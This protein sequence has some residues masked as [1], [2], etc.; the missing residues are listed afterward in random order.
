MGGP[1]LT[2]DDGWL[3]A[4]IAASPGQP[5]H[6]LEGD[7]VAEHVPGCNMAYRREALE[8]IGG[9]DTTYR[10]AGDDVDV[11]WRLQIANQWITFAPG[12]FVWHHRRQTVRTYLRQQAGYGEAEALLWFAY[13]D[14]FNRRGES[15]WRGG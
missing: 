11:C 3:A 13:P 14:R 2:P 10:K 8:G 4:C 1:N 15:K 12:A 7:Q 6:V 9:F 5:A